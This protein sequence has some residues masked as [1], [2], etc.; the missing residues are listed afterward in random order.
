MKKTYPDEALTVL[1][2][3]RWTASCASATSRPRSV[4]MCCAAIAQLCD[5][6]T[7]NSGPLAQAYGRFQNT[8]DAYIEQ[9]TAA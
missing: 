2:W 1:Y 7:T 3:R 4:S 9:K 8:L 5:L 6:K